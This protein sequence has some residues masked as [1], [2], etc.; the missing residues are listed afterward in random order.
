[1]QSDCQPQAIENKWIYTGYGSRDFGNLRNCGKG[2]WGVRRGNTGG[3]VD[4]VDIVDGVDVVDRVDVV[5]DVIFDPVH[6]AGRACETS[7]F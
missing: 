7:Y 3:H 1:M 2:D 4:K 6:P 5:N